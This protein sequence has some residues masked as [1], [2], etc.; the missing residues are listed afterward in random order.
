MAKILKEI[1]D[2]NIV[3]VMN[4]NEGELKDLVSRYAS[5][6]NKRARTIERYR[7]K[8]NVAQDALKF[9][10]RTGGLFTTVGDQPRYVNGE[11]TYSKTLNELREELAREIQFSK[12]KTLKVREARAVQEE[13]I[14]DAKEAYNKQFGRT[15]DQYGRETTVDTFDRLSEE[16]KKKVVAKFWDDFHKWQEEHPEQYETTEQRKK[17]LETYTSLGNLSEFKYQMNKIKEEKVNALQTAQTKTLE[18]TAFKP[19]WK[20]NWM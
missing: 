4:L 9:L 2:L 1:Q 5:E 17:A 18:E 12:M 11:L 6:L 13:R 14:K 3:D 16:D 20:G 8:P 7:D 10:D 15:T 19:K